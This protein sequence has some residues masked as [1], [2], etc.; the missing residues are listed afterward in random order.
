MKL[1]DYA[2]LCA[3][4]GMSASV[5]AQ[6][7]L[8]LTG[9]A[10]PADA[11]QATAP[12]PTQ[13]KPA[14]KAALQCN[15]DSCS[16]KD[17][18]VFRLRTRSYDQPV[19]QGTD[20]K[21]TSKALQ[22]D[23]RVTIQ[24]DEPAKPVA[25]PGK[26]TAVGKWSVQLPNGGVI[27]ATEDP[28]L[29]QPQMAVSGNNL[30]AYDGS[31]VT[32]PVKFYGSTNYSAF[33][34]RAEVV[35]FRGSDNDLVT[36]LATIP[37]KLGA[38]MEG[39]WD[40]SIN[41]STGA[42][43]RVG[44]ELI[45]VVRAW[46]DDKTYDETYPSR[47]QL[48]RPDE[49]EVQ[50][51]RT[52]AQAVQNGQRPLTDAAA[53]EM[54]QIQQVFGQNTLRLQNIPVYGS[55]VRI[56]GRNVPDQQ[57]VTINGQSM[58]VDLERKFVSEYLLPIGHYAFDVQVGKGGDASGARKKLD[59]DVTG[60]YFF[61]VGI[62]DFTLSGNSVS[63]S[64]EPLANQPQY[65]K[66]SLLEGRLAF[67][68]KGKAKGKYL[69][70]AQ[71]DTREKQVSQLFTGFWK[72]DATDVF[73][74]LD[75]DAYYPVYGDDST[76]YRD[77]DTMGRLYLRVDWD[78]NQALWGN[79]NTGLT[80]TEYAQYNRDL[81]GA[82]L[83][84]RSQNTTKYAEPS[85]VLR[86]FGSQAQSA[87]GHSEFLGTGGSLYYLKHTG[88]LPGSEQVV[89]EIRDP[90]TG[91]VINRVTMVSGVDYEIDAY[92]GRILLTRPLSQVASENVHTLTRDTP[93]TG[94]TQLLMVDYEYVPTGFKADDV[95]AGLRV[96]HWFGDHVGVGATYVDENRAGDDYRMAGADITLQ[97]GRGTYLKIE[98][99]HTQA[100]SAPIFYSTNGGLSFT[101]TNAAQPANGSG[102]ARAVEA[103][104]N[105]KELGWTQ[106]EWTAGAW[107]RDVDAGY[108]ISRYSIGQPVHEVGAEVLGDVSDVLRM[109]ARVSRAERG[110]DLLEQEQLTADWRL[111]E[112]SLLSAELRRVDQRTNGVESVGTLLAARYSKH[113]GTSLDIYG[114]G[115]VTLDDDG[116]KYA[117]NNA[118]TAGAKYIFG[119]LSNIGGEATVGDRGNA[120]SV[121]GEYRVSQNHT[122]YANYT[123]ST[124]TTQYD[125]LFNPSVTPGWTVGQRWQ[126]NS[127][128]NVFNES[129]FL[130]AP[131][132]SGLAHT[133]GMNFYPSQGW[134]TGFTLQQGSL[135][136]AD[137]KT[138]RQAISITGGYTSPIAQ[139][140][141]KLEWRKDT[142]AERRRQWVTTNWFNYKW[143]ESLRF[144]GRLNISDTQ[145]QTQSIAGARFVE[146]N[147]GFAWRPWN[148]TKYALLGKYTYLYDVSAL[149]Q[150][151]NDTAYYD[152]QSRVFSIE[153]IYHPLP[154]WEFSGKLAR[155]DGEV[156]FGRFTGAWESSSATFGAV[157]VRY[158]LI[159]TDW[160]ALAEYRWLGVDKGGIR[161]GVLL[162]IDRN[163]TKGL[164]VGVG[165]NFT[166]F[167][168]NLTD[169]SYRHR[170]WFL[171]VV[172]S[173]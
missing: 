30:V 28:S 101:Q 38:I 165:Y 150:V 128:V 93:L 33:M 47:M 163:I 29:G 61:G 141:S 143:N 16:S 89:L 151:G 74:Q 88:I 140:Q 149:P 109:Y 19:T 84:W 80:G 147:V 121:N 10:S 46:S 58:P 158:G 129:Q 64:V 15:D 133:F 153:G 59:I 37:L 106:R 75:P 156:R 134:N 60:R 130:K 69:W 5:H 164:R 62:A 170:G 35:V 70:T 14:D 71:A 78:K 24:V 55:R 50:Q 22:P 23:R 105:T 173:Y 18:L 85:S 57:V 83:A 157:Q 118:F 102:T 36:P 108:S 20:K 107:W 99:T 77:V 120:V 114:I 4:S 87:P 56:Q 72:A 51:Q 90:T 139:W 1:L 132:Q 103:R 136:Q 159:H 138:D 63:G 137:G 17:G 154:R 25:L 32:K 166:D 110:N 13:D 104:I 171:N 95:A 8:P 117:K 160:N 12:Q 73:R 6:S 148:S 122:L 54:L 9:N 92:Q 144:A 167:S 39:E 48:V 44:D 172:G 11:Q 79:Y 152:Q 45:Y 82:A 34:K 91:S 86:A 168:D 162:G 100:T 41:A 126:L 26:A 135:E 98:Q 40:G 123:Y 142:G 27:W 131:N 111:N 119:N 76:T 3:L 97:A 7:A 146:G 68:L 145:D 43:L 81:Y 125:P 127:K 2:L 49:L 113:I 116:G 155:R 112:R 169:F 94:Y 124:D 42:P 66:D 161:K 52:T 67:Y 115:Q 21:S 31:K 53:S 65:T 96:K